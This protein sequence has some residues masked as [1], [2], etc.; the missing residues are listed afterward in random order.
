MA[1]GLYALIRATLKYMKCGASTLYGIRRGGKLASSI[2][3][4]RRPLK[5]FYTVN[6]ITSHGRRS[7]D[8]IHNINQKPHYHHHPKQT[9]YYTNDPL[10]PHNSSNSFFYFF[11]FFEQEHCK[12]YHSTWNL[13]RL[14]SILKIPNKEPS[15]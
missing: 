7:S 9:T 11:Y 5:L 2:S 10:G 3:W 6:R 14:K 8:T 12:Y 13:A 15:F 4:G 1:L